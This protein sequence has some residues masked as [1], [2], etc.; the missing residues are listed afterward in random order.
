MVFKGEKLP[1]KKDKKQFRF[2]VTFQ[3]ASGT[4]RAVAFNDDINRF[5]EELEYL[6]VSF[7]H[8]VHLQVLG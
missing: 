3:D 6:K 7:S 1:W 5:M 2:N 4:V 8:N